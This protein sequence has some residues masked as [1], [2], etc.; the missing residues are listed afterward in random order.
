M[1]FRLKQSTASQKVPLGP[2]VDATDGAT[3][4]DGLG[5]IA[6]S[7]IK[8]WKAGGTSMS[9]APGTAVFMVDGTYVLTVDATA[10]DTLG[11]LVIVASPAGA[12][13]I[14][15][16]CEVLPQPV[17]DS[18]QANL[19]IASDLKAVTGSALLASRFA[20]MCD[21]IVVGVTHNTTPCTTESITTFPAIGLDPAPT[22]VDQFRDKVIV[23]TASATNEP[24][25]K[26]VGRRIKA[27]T[28]SDPCVL[29]ID[30]LPVAPGTLN[31]FIIVDASLAKLT[32]E[33]Y[34]QADIEQIVGS[35]QAA[36]LLKR[37]ALAATSGTLAAGST[38]TVL[39]IASLTPAPTG[40]DQL[41]GR[42]VLMVDEPGTAA[43]LK[44][45][46]QKIQSSSTTSITLEAGFTSAPAAGTVIIIL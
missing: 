42:I 36:L 24:G 29:T 5:P 41:R 39:Q 28:N 19:G 10:T 12:R 38:Q 21:T 4:E 15:V 45:Q 23:F 16:E 27:S 2:F 8:I 7:D 34:V 43:G 25:A 3:L 22:Q 6:A 44:I 40:P 11:P 35:A 26:C 17:Y 14:R 46:G 31:A 33:G 37:M 9:D 1:I 20:S 13:P 30:A 18:L 32:P